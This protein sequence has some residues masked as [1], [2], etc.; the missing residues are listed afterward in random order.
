VEAGRDIA[1][2]AVANLLRNRTRKHR[3]RRLILARNAPVLFVGA[4]NDNARHE[5]ADAIRR[6]AKVLSFLEARLLF[7]ISEGRTYGELARAQGV[8]AGTVK[9]WVRRARLKLKQ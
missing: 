4:A 3:N 7:G 8:P 2:E 6:A 1:P 9:T 5:A